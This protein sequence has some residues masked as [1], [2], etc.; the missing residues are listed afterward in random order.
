MAER[1]L[2]ITIKAKDLYDRELK[3]AKAQFKSASENIRQNFVANF[4]RAAGAVIAFKKAFDFASEAAKFDQQQQAFA[5]LAASHGQNAAAMVEGLKQMSAQTISTA[6]IMESAGKAMVLGI[7]AEQLA[8]MMQIARASSRITGET[9]QKSF[10]DIA[11]GV[12]RQSRM[13]LDNLGII[14]NADEAYAEYAATLGITADQLTEVQRKQAFTNAVMKAGQDI[15]KRVGVEGMTAAEAMQAFTAQMDN[16]RIFFGKLVISVSSGLS[17]I[18]FGFSTVFAGIVGTLA[19]GIAKIVELGESLP[20]VGDK[21]KAASEAIK[22][23]AQ[24][25][26]EA[27]SQAAKLSEQSS[28]V[29]ISIWKQKEAI[30]GV[31]KARTEAAA[32]PE[33]TG[34]E[35]R[36]VQLQS[37]RDFL[38]RKVDAFEESQERIR[39]REMDDFNRQRL[40][41]AMQLEAIRQFH[42][43]ELALEAANG[44]TSN[45]LERLR[46]TQNMQFAKAEAD[47]KISMGRLSLQSAAGFM[48]NLFIATGKNNKKMFEAYKAFAI[49]E[50]IMSTYA[51][52]TKAFAQYG[53]PYGAVAAGLVIAGGLAQVA[54]IRS[55]T[56]GGGATATSVGGGGG[57]SIGSTVFGGGNGGAAG[58]VTADQ[59]QQQP[60]QQITVNLQIDGVISAEEM[61]RHVEM[62]LS[63]AMRRAVDRSVEIPS[64]AT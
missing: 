52:A 44:A 46:V 36:E 63:P 24:F 11:L 5:N 18:A 16:A 20:F 60:S 1:T 33:D 13:I 55:Q 49:G 64:N 3:K 51:G 41:Y 28:N 10:E 30:E 32:V 50:A 17:A 57:T 61:D 26:F 59:G 56:M 22:G 8:E 34:F 48:H 31:T 2:E 39:Q 62:N 38:N 4:A 43:D 23:F 12:G 19:K 7:P 54:Q 53:W 29:A 42:T 15:I 47:F 21:F 45:E 40:G 35:G 14:V 6:G 58:L 25:E 27:A 9:V 37:Y